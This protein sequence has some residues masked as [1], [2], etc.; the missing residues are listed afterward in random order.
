MVTVERVI[1]GYNGKELFLRTWEDVENPKGIVQ[2]IHGMVDHSGRYDHFAKYLNSKGYVVYA[3]DHRGHG[4]T[5][6]KYNE[7]GYLGEDGFNSVVEDE[8]II[9]KI[10]KSEYGNIPTYIFAHSFGSFI[11]QEY[12]T[13]YSDHID[14]IFLSGSAKR[15]GFEIKLGYFVS[16]IQKKL[17][18]PKKVGKFIDRFS[19]GGFNKRIKNPKTKFDWLTRNETVVNE[20]INDEHCKF[21]SS[22]DFYNNLFIGLKN[23]YK[24]EKLKSI[25]K[26]LKIIILAGDKDPVGNYG[27]SVKRLYN[28]YVD[29]GIKNIHFKLFKDGRHEI[30]NE[31]NRDEVYDYILEKIEEN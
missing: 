9:T 1:S 11:G 8:F 22:I 30:I 6:K 29:L 19:F 5:G 4:E 16:N 15:D 23:L 24:E 31:I 10:A 28:Q 26:K 27:E 2:I 14:G 3:D 17:F 13:R 12:I 25:R 20:Y 7:Y 21:I 18:N